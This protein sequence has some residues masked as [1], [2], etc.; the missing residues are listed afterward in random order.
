MALAPKVIMTWFFTL[1]F[2]ILLALRLDQNTTWNWF[3][4]FL[5]LW[6]FDFLVLCIQLLRIVTHVR[7]GH[8][9]HLEMTMSTKIFFVIG[10]GL[11]LLF[12]VLLCVR[13]EYKHDLALF[14]V[15]IP[16]WVILIFGAVRLTPWIVKQT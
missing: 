12:Q 1:L 13:L 11:K 3:I 15:F 2:L 6:I 7:T 5:P 4:I 10:I 16:L 8:D 9:R 14:Y